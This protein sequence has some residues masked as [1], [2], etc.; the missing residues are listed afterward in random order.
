MVLQILHYSLK[1][2]QIKFMQCV[3]D[4]SLAFQLCIF[5]L[6]LFVHTNFMGLTE[7]NVNKMFGRYF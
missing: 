6:H 3:D 7:S 1:R 5:A 4:K 2:Y